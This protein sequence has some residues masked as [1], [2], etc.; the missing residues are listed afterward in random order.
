[1]VEK[2]LEV[3]VPGQIKTIHVECLNEQGAD[4]GNTTK[5]KYP[6]PWL[7]FPL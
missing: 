3:H 6:W 5:K 2:N 4:L 1:M 7:V